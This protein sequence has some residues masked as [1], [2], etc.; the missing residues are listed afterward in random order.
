MNWTV[1]E[2]KTIIEWNRR[3]K[4]ARIKRQNEPVI[5]TTKTYYSVSNVGFKQNGTWCCGLSIP[6]LV[7]EL[8][9]GCCE[10]ESWFLLETKRPSTG[11]L[12]GP[13]PL[14]TL[15]RWQP[16]LAYNQR[17][18][19]TFCWYYCFKVF[20]RT[21]L[22]VTVKRLDLHRTHTTWLQKTQTLE[23]TASSFWMS[24]RY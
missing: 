23:Q 7:K 1:F 18:M 24:E 16:L 19:A 2:W 15:F 17:P 8:I 21:C 10:Q 12:N 4:W 14:D 6:K 5:T 13:L 11:N 22:Q 3:I 20:K 9:Y